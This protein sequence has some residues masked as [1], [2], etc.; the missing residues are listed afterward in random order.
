[1][2]TVLLLITDF[3]SNYQNIIIIIYELEGYI[4]V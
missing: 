2:D 1:M 4:H 3:W